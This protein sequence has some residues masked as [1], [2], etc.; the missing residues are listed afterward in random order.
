MEKIISK[1]K[2]FVLDVLFPIECLGCKKEGEWLCRECLV[3]IPLNDKFNCPLCDRFSFWGRVCER[4][5]FGQKN[6]EGVLVASHYSNE[7]LQQAIQLLK[8]QFVTGLAH[9]LGDLLADFLKKLENN[10]ELQKNFLNHERVKFLELEKVI[11]T[12]DLFFDQSTILIPVP[13]HKKRLRERGFN[14]SELL[15]K[16]LS[17]K[18]GQRVIDKAIIRKKYTLPQVDLKMNERKENIRDAFFCLDSALIEDKKVILIDDVLTTGATMTE[19]AKVL[20]AA[21]AKEVWGL[22]LA[23]NL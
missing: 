19:C 13:L 17:E 14:Q 20:K 23:R 8:Y 4:C 16:R 22:A 7:I 9:P 21:G 2:N 1:I 3:E 6:L 15:A 11:K 5:A 12:P 18:T 10:K